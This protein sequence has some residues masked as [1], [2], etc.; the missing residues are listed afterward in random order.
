MRV[1]MRAAPGVGLAA[2][3][4]GIGLAVAV[5]EDPGAPDVDDDGL[6]IVLEELL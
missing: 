1:T 4:V 2:P 6:A 3:Q 5:V